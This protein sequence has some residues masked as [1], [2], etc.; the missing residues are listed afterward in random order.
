MKTDTLICCDALA[1]AMAAGPEVFA[2]GA[3]GAAQGAAR[4]ARPAPLPR[5]PGVYSPTTWTHC[6]GE[7]E[8]ADDTRYSGEFEDGKFHGRGTLTFRSG[9]QYDGEFRESRFHGRGAFTRSDGSVL[10]SG[11]WENGV[12]IREE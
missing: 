11:L 1:W 2:Q 10:R 6:V 5:C 12:L 8:F 7:G 3:A 9:S 4:T